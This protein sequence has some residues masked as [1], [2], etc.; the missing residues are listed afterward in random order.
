LRF[1]PLWLKGCTMNIERQTISLNGLR[2]FSYHGAEVQEAVAG[3]WYRVDVDICA[4]VRIALNS[5]SLNDT[6]NYSRV[7]SIVKRQM[8]IPSKLI[9]HVAGRIA[10][11]LIG[12]FGDRIESMNIRVVKENPPV[13]VVCEESSFLLSLRR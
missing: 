7:A 3:A 8:D 12:C 11:D 13:G 4:D 5:D 2:F 6:V 10:T 9:E 1:F